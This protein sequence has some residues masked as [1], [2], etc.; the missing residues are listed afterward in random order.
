MS[1]HNFN[2]V[3]LIRKKRDGSSLS[4]DE[5]HCFIKEFTKDQL[6][7][8]QM[9]AFLMAGFIRGFDD[10]EAAALTDAMLHSGKILD[11]SDIPGKKVD[12]HSTGDVGD[13]LS[14]ILAPIVAS[15][16]IPVPMISG[17]GLGHTGGTLDKLESITGF[18]VDLSLKRYR[19]I[20]EKIH[21]VMA[22]QTEEVAPADKRLYALR[23]VTATV[24][25]IPLIASSIMSKKLAEGIDALVLDVK[26]GSGAFMTELDEAIALAEAL[27]AIG[28]RFDKETIAYLTDMNQ[29]LGRA[30]G[31]WLEVAES[32]DALKG[33]G[34]DDVME[35]THTLAGTMICLAEKADSIDEGVEM[36]REAVANG[37]A[38]EKLLALVR[39][40]GGDTELIRHPE[41]YEQA[42][43]RFTLKAARDGYI[44][45]MDAYKMGMASLELGAGRR[46]KEDSI[47]PSAGILLERKRG[48]YV[49]SG[50]TIARGYTN[51][52]AVVEAVLP[53]ME[54]AVSIG[55]ERPETSRLIQYRADSRGVH[56]LK[57]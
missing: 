40:Q 7:D 13:K 55:D 44:R 30:I 16:G 53:V 23:D 18:T 49:N 56:P 41:R 26:F 52:E 38:F 19:H 51:K 36:S 22:G 31:N 12:K 11:L 45:E 33:E 46:R 37:Q 35:I 8:Y 50:E 4:A 27:V 3:S 54:E 34:P 20:L 43:H 15:W 1:S 14:L 32:I 29:P 28:E 47:D 57:S 42:D 21:M 48:D 10:R 17:R 39:E 25:S 5:I 2:P 24:E 6:P 9:S